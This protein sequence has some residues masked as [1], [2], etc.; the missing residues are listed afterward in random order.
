[1]ILKEAIEKRQ[2]EEIESIRTNAMERARK[3]ASLLKEK[4]GAKR[5]ILFGS[6]CSKIYLHERSD[7]DL[8]VEG[9]KS[10]DILRAGFDAWVVAEPF[11]VDI[12]PTEVAEERMIKI[13][14]KDGIEL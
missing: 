14:I 8:L 11:D 4:Y 5:V 12:I 7:I 9:I 10:S 6:L 3:V 2:A 1:M 13:A